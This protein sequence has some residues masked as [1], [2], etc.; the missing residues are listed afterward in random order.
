MTEIHEHPPV[1][2]H[3][4]SSDAGRPAPKKRSRAVA[5]DTVLLNTANPYQQILNENPNRLEAWIIPSGDGEFVIAQSETNASHNAS[6]ANNA[7][8]SADGAF[9]PKPA[10]AS[11]TV[12]I[13]CHTTNPVWVSGTTGVLAVA[14][15]RVGVIE[16]LDQ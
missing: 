3:V 15:I 13:P 9:V 6:Q 12:P 7:A 16:I 2:V 14:S 5:M 10:S 8:G 11:V 1:R 4:V